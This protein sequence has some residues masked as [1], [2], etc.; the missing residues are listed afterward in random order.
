MKDPELDWFADMIPEIKPSAAILILPEL[1]TETVVPNKDN[2][3]S[4]MHFSSKFA[5]AEITE[6]ESAGWGEDGDLNWDDNSW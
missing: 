5:A 3:S 1:R 2:V 6:G 4:V